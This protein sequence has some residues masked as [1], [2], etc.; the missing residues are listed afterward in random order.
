MDQVSLSWWGMHDKNKSIL[1]QWIITFSETSG[2]PLVKKH[3]IL[4]LITPKAV[5]S[6]IPHTE[7]Y[8]KC[9]NSGLTNSCDTKKGQRASL[10]SNKSATDFKVS[11]FCGMRLH[12]TVC[13]LLEINDKLMVMIIKYMIITPVVQWFRE[14]TTSLSQNHC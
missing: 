10:Q 4:I 12:N 11:V 7:A 14:F 3:H 9:I 5:R 6:Y 1:P 13:Q 2:E 8:I